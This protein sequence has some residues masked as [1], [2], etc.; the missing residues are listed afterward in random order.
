MR[1]TNGGPNIWPDWASQTLD[2]AQAGAA[3]DHKIQVRRIKMRRCQRFSSN[4]ELCEAELG[5]LGGPPRTL[6]PC[7]APG[8]KSGRGFVQNLVGIGLIE[9]GS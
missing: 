4:S 9:L 7:S 1:S 8:P 3:L 2:L 5:H 6:G